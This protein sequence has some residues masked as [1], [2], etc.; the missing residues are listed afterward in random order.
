[1]NPAT[2]F[3]LPIPASSLQSIFHQT[4]LAPPQLLPPIRSGPYPHHVL[5][6]VF[7][8]SGLNPTTL[9]PHSHLQPRSTAS[10]RF[11][12]QA[13]TPPTPLSNFCPTPLLSPTTTQS[14]ANETS[15][16]HTH[17][18]PTHNHW[19]PPPP[20]AN[21]A[22]STFPQ[23]CN[24]H[25]YFSPWSLAPPPAPTPPLV[26]PPPPTPPRASPLLPMLPLAPPPPM[27]PPAS[28]LLPTPTSTTTCS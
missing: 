5:A 18:S 1:M 6:S 19:L 9:P 15:T 13:S 21:T 22:P 14:S 3:P 8:Q 2:R 25:P 12:K 17:T 26:P 23:C 10:N 7:H 11:S 4:G 27:P 24:G 16:P 20:M 28:P